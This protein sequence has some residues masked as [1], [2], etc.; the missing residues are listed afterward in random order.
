MYEYKQ[1]YRRTLPHVHSPG[2]TLFVTFRLDG[3][4]PKS[5]LRE[6]AI[7]KA[8]LLEPA[9]ESY[10]STLPE[11]ILAFNRR[12]L[13]KCEDVLH[14]S[15]SGPVW[16]KDAKIAQVVAD[17]MHYLDGRSY[18]LHAYCIMCNHVHAV[19]TPFLN[20]RSVFEKPDSLRTAFESSNPTLAAIMKSLKGFTAREA[21][22]LLGRKGT[23]WQAESYDREI[24]DES[25]FWRVIKYV[26][27]NPGRQESF[28]NGRNIRIRGYRKA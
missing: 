15:S 21:N 27:N 20:E 11:R 19:F 13:A 9:D 17:A 7:E 16:L 22:K 28:K 24:R 5:V 2:A 18:C 8:I 10:P 25:E 4:I 14:E 3:S 26:L 6:W 23:F 1:F 12:W